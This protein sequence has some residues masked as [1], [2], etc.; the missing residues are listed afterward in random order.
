MSRKYTYSIEGWTGREWFTLGGCRDVPMQWALG[1]LFGR[2]EVCGPTLT[3]RVM[4]SDGREVLAEE[5][6]EDVGIGMVAGWPSPEQYERA[7][8][9][10]LAKAKRLREMEEGKP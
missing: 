9:R 8:E 2:R 5:G 7:A 4:R 3:L 6:K 10:A 1:F